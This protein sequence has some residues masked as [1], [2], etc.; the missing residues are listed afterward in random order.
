MAKGYTSVFKGFEKYLKTK[1]QEGRAI[2]ANTLLE[3]IYLLQ[4]QGDP[5]SLQSAATL[6]RQYYKDNLEN[7]ITGAIDDLI[8]KQKRV[9]GGDLSKSASE[10]SEKLYIRLSEIAEAADKNENK[11][12]DNVDNY[13]ILN[14]KED[15]VEDFTP[16]SGNNRLAAMVAG[17]P[18][19]QDLPNIVKVL[20]GKEF[21]DADTREGLGGMSQQLQEMVE[22]FT[23]SNKDEAVY[24]T[25]QKRC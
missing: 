25:I 3:P 21:S 4:S 22:F 12:W 19:P 2:A 6:M 10:T 20:K 23:L 15:V 16:I 14:F 24:K 8:T 9:T 17:E 5:E 7:T 13:A 18:D 11:L 1:T